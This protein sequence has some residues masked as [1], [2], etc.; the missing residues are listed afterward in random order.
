MRKE[1]FGL[2]LVVVC[3]GMM[4]RPSRILKVKRVRNEV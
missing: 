4:E 3:I 1:I 2:A